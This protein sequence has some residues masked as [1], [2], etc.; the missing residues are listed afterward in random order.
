MGGKR[1]NIFIYTVPNEKWYSS[2]LN[3]EHFEKLIFASFKTSI[4]IWDFLTK[5][6]V[7]GEYCE[8]V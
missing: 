1:E 2:K 7:I 3:S 5:I 4:D 8:T 6:S